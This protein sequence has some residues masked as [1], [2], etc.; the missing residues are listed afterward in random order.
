MRPLFAVLCA[1]LA[2]CALESDQPSAPGVAAPVLVSGPALPLCLFIVDCPFA[3]HALAC[4]DPAPMALV[5]HCAHWP[6]AVCDG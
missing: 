4:Y 3:C 1:F 5:G 6:A 2:G